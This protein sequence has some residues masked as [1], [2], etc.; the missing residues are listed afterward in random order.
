MWLSV[1]TYLYF[2]IYVVHDNY[3]FIHLFC[4]AYVEGML[5]CQRISRSFD[6][7]LKLKLFGM[8]R[9]NDGTVMQNGLAGHD[10]YANTV[11]V[12]IHLNEKP[13]S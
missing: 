6:L 8:N 5:V 9:L 4:C 10:G 13:E 2:L 3:L 11:K 1:P 12:L 7:E